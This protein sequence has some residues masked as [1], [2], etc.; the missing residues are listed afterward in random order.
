MFIPA[1]VS[2]FPHTK[3]PSISMFEKIWVWVGDVTGFDSEV[4]IVS[5]SNCLLYHLLRLST[6][7]AVSTM[8]TICIGTI[9]EK[10]CDAGAAG[11]D[12]KN[13]VFLS[14]FTAEQLPHLLLG[15][16]IPHTIS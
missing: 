8:S 7:L 11:F 12:I 1:P 10:L 16:I 13:E 3:M 14:S 2:C 4:V 5:S 6:E 15:G 9:L